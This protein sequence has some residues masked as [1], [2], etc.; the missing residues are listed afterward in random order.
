MVY[1]EIPAELITPISIAECFQ[2]DL[3]DGMVFEISK[4]NEE[5]SSWICFDSLAQMQTSNGFVTLRIGDEKTFP[6]ETPLNILRELLQD[7]L[8]QRKKK[9]RNLWERQWAFFLMML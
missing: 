7:F 9:V 2:K 5:Q 3:S 6:S 8:A 4:P 1:R